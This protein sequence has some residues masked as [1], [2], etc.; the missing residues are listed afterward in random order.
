M[1]VLMW[2]WCMTATGADAQDVA[3]GNDPPQEIVSPAF[4]VTDAS[5][6]TA[7]ALWPRAAWLAR[8]AHRASLPPRDLRGRRISLVLPKRGVRMRRASTALRAIVALGCLPRVIDA[9]RVLGDLD[10]RLV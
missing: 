6:M 2:A 4:V 3:L 5:C 10:A 8:R 9:L 1:R 7:D